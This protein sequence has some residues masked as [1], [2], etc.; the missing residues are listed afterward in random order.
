MF[1]KVAGESHSIFMMSL[2]LQH[3]NIVFLLLMIP[4][5]DGYNTNSERARLVVSGPGSSFGGPGSAGAGGRPPIVID[6]RPE[7]TITPRYLEVNVGNPVEF[8]CTATGKNSK[9][10]APGTC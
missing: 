6:A 2:F 5:T 10:D 4:A 8:Q 3:F 7:V 9:L 1:V